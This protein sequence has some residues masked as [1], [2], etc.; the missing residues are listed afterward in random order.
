MIVYTHD[1]NSN[2]SCKDADVL[3]SFSPLYNDEQFGLGMTTTPKV[4]VFSSN[5]CTKKAITKQE[6]AD[7]AASTAFSINCKSRFG[8]TVRHPCQ[9]F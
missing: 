9:Q 7:N 4:N 2:H 6:N 8:L 1:L 3:F 5:V